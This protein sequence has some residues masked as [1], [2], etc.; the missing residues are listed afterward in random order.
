MVKVKEDLTGQHFGK[1][2]VIEQAEDYVSPLGKHEAQWLCKCNCESHTIK[3][4]QQAHLKSRKSLS[5]GCYN[6]ER[7]RETHK[8]TNK[9][10]LYE[11][12]GILWTSNTNEE[13]Y[14]DIEDAEQ[15]LKYCWYK[16]CTGY[17]ASTI[18]DKTTR[19]H[20][21]LGF[22][23]Y[24]HCNRNKLD[25]RKENLRPCTDS[26]NGTNKNLRVDNTSGVI[27]VYWFSRDKKWKAQ[28][29]INKKTKGLGTFDNKKDAIKARLKAEVEHYGEFAPQ[30]HL[31]EEYGIFT[32]EKLNENN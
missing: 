8:K 2:E 13:V 3:V 18:N 25:N 22:K 1:W 19:L 32:K 21:H 10:I 14:F 24:D 27:G 15:I 9:Y 17:P 31:F 5:C 11:D 12:Y 20:V 23:W 29:N 16:D 4:V 30:K 6:K 26:Q 28:I 7:I